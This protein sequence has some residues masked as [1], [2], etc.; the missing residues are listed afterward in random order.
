M[1]VRSNAPG[2]I[3]T[4]ATIATTTRACRNHAAETHATSTARAA[5]PSTC[6]QCQGCGGRPASMRNGTRLTTET[7]A[8]ATMG[9]EVPRTATT[10]ATAPATS[11]TA[12]THGL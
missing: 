9:V 2:R 8:A 7:A 4:A 1:P 6:T 11:H 3:T 5:T 10:I 12:A